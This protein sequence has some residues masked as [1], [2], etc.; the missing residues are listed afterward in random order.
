MSKKTI[1][2]SKKLK[3]L[4]TDVLKHTKK[5]NRLFKKL[6]DDLNDLFYPQSQSK[7]KQKSK[8]EAIFK[9]AT[10]VLGERIDKEIISLKELPEKT[11]TEL[12]EYKAKRAEYEQ[13]SHK[14]SIKL[15]TLKNRYEAVGKALEKITESK[16]AYEALDSMEELKTQLKNYK[17]LVNEIISTSSKEQET[18]KITFSEGDTIW[19]DINALDEL[20][21]D[22]SV[23]TQL[24][25]KTIGDILEIVLGYY[26]FYNTN[27]QIQG[28]VE[29]LQEIVLGEKKTSSVVEA[30]KENKTI[31]TALTPKKRSKGNDKQ[32]Y[33]IGIGSKTLAIEIVPSYNDAYGRSQKMDIVLNLPELNKKEVSPLRVSAKNWHELKGDFGTTSMAYAIT[34]S[35]NKFQKGSTDLSNSNSLLYQT[36]KEIGAEKKEEGQQLQVQDAHNL[37]KYSIAADILM[38]YSQSEG[39]VD[40]II[41]NDRTKPKIHVIN[42]NTLMNNIYTNIRDFKVFNYDK[43]TFEANF[44][45]ILNEQNISITNESGNTENINRLELILRYLQSTQTTIEYS[46]IKDYI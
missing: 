36:F 31:T 21:E 3:D 42:L 44:K 30:N 24:P 6:E 17:V 45:N 33:T 7:D 32:K 26:S 19:D 35:Y 22:I 43:E 28:T 20:F 27:K 18:E 37:A 34:R 4:H 5:G 46:A 29:E 12:D 14:Q 10:K 16:T 13:F 25:T 2:F 9:A 8:R 15:Q 38:G 40:T 11:L 1:N 23:Q 41:I 39:Y